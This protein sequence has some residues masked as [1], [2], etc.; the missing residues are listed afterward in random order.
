MS[1]SVWEN[2]AQLRKLVRFCPLFTGYSGERTWIVI[3]NRLQGPCYLS[4]DD[5]DRKIR[6]R[7]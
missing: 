3:E 5:N 7:K 6:V 2:L 4:R 1:V